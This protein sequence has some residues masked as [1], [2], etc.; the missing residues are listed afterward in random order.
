M[1][2]CRPTCLLLILLTALLALP[3]LAEDPKPV[4]GED[5]IL[6]PAV[7]EGLCVSNTFQ[8]NMVLQRD[9]PIT[10]WGW[11]DAGNKVTVTFGGNSATATAGNDRYWKAELPALPANDKPQAMT[12]KANGQTLTL[13]NILV[14][15]VW[16]LG[17]QSNME[18]PLSNVE[19]GNLEIISANF[20]EMRILSIPVGESPKENKKSFPSIYQWSSWSSRHFKKGSWDI[21]TPEIAKDL[22]AIGYV[23]ARR[24]HMTVGVPIGVIDAS[25]GG[26]TVETWTPL[27][28]LRKMDSKPTT[29]LLAEWDEKVNSFDPEAD[30]LQRIEKKKQWIENKTKQGA[31]LSEKDKQLPTE[32]EPGPIANHNHPGS[33]YGA[34]IAP[35][36]GLSVRGAIFHQGYNNAFNGQEGVDMYADV[37]PV[38]IKAWR[39]AFN[40]PEMPFG[41]LSLCT[42]GNPQTLDDYSEKMFNTGIELR[43]VQYKTFEDLYKAGD[44]NIGF[45]ST[46]DLRRRWYH[47]QVK[48]PAGERIARWALATQYG[49]GDRTLPWKPPFITGME[50]KDGTLV[51][52][53]DQ[54]VMDPQDGAMLGFSIAG[55]AREFHPATAA[56]FV[57]GKDDRGRDQLDRKK[58]VLSSIMVSD[59]IHYRYAWG[60]NPLANV[61]LTGNKDV[62]L[63]TQKSDDWGLEEVPLSV[64]ES[65]DP[66]NARKNRGTIL[67]ALKQ[68][69]RSR[70]L[71]EAQ[72]TIKM[73]GQE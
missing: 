55:E 13:D 53:F 7:S 19:N 21:L 59:P 8:S 20:P 64:V 18:F 71:T 66:T 47:P 45:A 43:A 60:R 22:S 70:R 54:D 2:T 26:T 46:Y 32:V 1:K 40:D 36:E 51:V 10:I 42:D 23:F 31:N 62:P 5:L 35:L 67:N 15:D 33:C 11:A 57:K 3:T 29:A 48:L 25:R 12:V 44:Q 14:G 68:L 34:M 56:Y 4:R 27:D 41:I 69:D 58:L 50:A 73:L 38:M 65:L 49:Y 39:S 30:L 16:V 6:V 37:F 52:S 72:Q 17:G 9:K 63:G 24:I 28:H 61:Q